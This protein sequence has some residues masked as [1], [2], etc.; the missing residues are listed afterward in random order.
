MNRPALFRH[1]DDDWIAAFFRRRS[2]EERYQ[3]RKMLEERFPRR[4]A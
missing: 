2:S 1:P 4:R 3:M